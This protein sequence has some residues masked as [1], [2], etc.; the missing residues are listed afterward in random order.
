MK[1]NQAWV[2]GIVS[3]LQK[4]AGVNK[5]ATDAQVKAAIQTYAKAYEDIRRKL[6]AS[7]AGRQS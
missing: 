4:N 6:G 3:M 2:E 5:A 1:T 7:R